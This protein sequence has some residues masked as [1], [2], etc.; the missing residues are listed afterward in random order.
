VALVAIGV[1]RLAV[2]DNLAPVIP[3][4]TPR[5]SSEARSSALCVKRRRTTS[6]IRPDGTIEGGR[7][8][9]QAD[10]DLRAKEMTSP[11]APN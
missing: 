2:A 8:P 11:R 3:S 9:V 7:G 4:R 10:L 5:S 1:V 6:M